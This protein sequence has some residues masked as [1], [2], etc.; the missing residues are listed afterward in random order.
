MSKKLNKRRFRLNLFKEDINI[1]DFY[2]CNQA[3]NIFKLYNY[4]VAKNMADIDR[5]LVNIEQLAYAMYNDSVNRK[6]IKFKK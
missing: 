2:M 6:I 5:D 3:E 1:S 4:P